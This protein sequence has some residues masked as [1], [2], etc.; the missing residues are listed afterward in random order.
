MRKGQFICV[1]AAVLNKI[2]ITKETLSEF[3][4]LS[5]CATYKKQ[6][7]TLMTSSCQNGK[8]IYAGLNDRL[9]FVSAKLIPFLSP[10]HSLSSFHPAT[11]HTPGPP[12]SFPIYPLIHAYI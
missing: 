7:S 11:P 10:S 4:V 3:L 8:R 1:S 12:P 2:I 6:V 9:N 5:N